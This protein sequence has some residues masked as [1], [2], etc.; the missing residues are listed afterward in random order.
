MEI[1]ER[2]MKFINSLHISNAE[3]ERKCGLGT[4]VV[5]KF[6]NKT[7]S[8]TY[9]RITAIYPQLNIEWLRT[10]SGNMLLEFLPKTENRHK[11]YFTVEDASQLQVDVSNLTPVYDIDATCGRLFRSWDTEK[12]VGYVSLDSIHA[13][14]KIISAYGDS[15]EPRIHSGDRIVVREIFNFADVLYYGLVYLIITE[16]FRMLKIIHR[17]STPGS[18]ILHSCNA[19]YEDFPLQVEKIQRLFLVENIISITNML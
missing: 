5:N 6:S 16:E 3:F 15:M 4:G 18:I 11:T 13:D 2:L 17:A 14:S 19:I 9:D 10:G 12:I 8:A 1:K 7:R